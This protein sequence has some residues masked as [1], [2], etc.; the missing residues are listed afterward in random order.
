MEYLLPRR[1]TLAPDALN[2]GGPS[3]DRLAQD[4]GYEPA[5][6]FGTA[7]RKRFGRSPGAFARARRGRDGRLEVSAR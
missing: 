1:M 6:A 2:R 3:L 4:I 7:F 5:S